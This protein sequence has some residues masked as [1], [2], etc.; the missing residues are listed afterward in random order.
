MRTNLNLDN[1]EKLL[2]E[3]I[4]LLVYGTFL[5]KLSAKGEI[6]ERFFFLSDEDISY[7]HYFSKEKP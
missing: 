7:L 2:Q 5:K 4:N 1:P 6:H 3:G